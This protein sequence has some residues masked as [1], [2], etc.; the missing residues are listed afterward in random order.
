MFNP[1]DPSTFKPSIDEIL[2]DGKSTNP[3]CPDSFK[4]Y[5]TATELI[6]K[7]AKAVR[8]IGDQ[9]VIW[10]DDQECPESVD[11]VTPDKVNK[12]IILR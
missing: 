3:N 2:K 4:K 9:K 7:L 8:E 6:E 1:P 10:C 5:M 11:H 12:V